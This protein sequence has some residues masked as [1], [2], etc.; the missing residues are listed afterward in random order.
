M[1]VDSKVVR[2][3][4]TTERGRYDVGGTSLM[5]T[6]FHHMHHFLPSLYGQI[7][8]LSKNVHGN[9]VLIA[10]RNGIQMRIFIETKLVGCHRRSKHIL[11]QATTRPATGCYNPIVEYCGSRKH[12]LELEGA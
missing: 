8:D 4:V 2:S 12:D 1:N 11:L 3:E 10:S 6:Q 5:T 9:P 7:Q